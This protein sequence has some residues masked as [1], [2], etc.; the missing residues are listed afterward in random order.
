MQIRPQT[1]RK[2]CALG[3]HNESIFS[4]TAADSQSVT[5]RLPSLEAQAFF[6]VA[7]IVAEG[8]S[9]MS[10]VTF[11]VVVMRGSLGPSAHTPETTSL[12]A[13]STDR[14]RRRSA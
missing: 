13:S 12:S 6:V 9:L 11:V 2:D 10:D 8:G 1:L 14:P 7:F 4:A 3:R 5:H